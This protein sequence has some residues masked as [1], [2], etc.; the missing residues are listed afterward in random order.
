M[1]LTLG[2]ILVNFSYLAISIIYF[3]ICFNIIMCNLVQLKYFLNILLTIDI[4][5]DIGILLNDCGRFLL[6]DILIKVLF[7][8]SF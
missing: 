8:F 3:I 1:I 4:D 2:L 7:Y 6:Y 5:T